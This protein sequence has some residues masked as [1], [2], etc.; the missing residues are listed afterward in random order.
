MTENLLYK[1]EEKVIMLLK[2]LE[3][4]RDELNLV[5]L[6]NSSLKAEKTNS[7]KK[8]QELVSL[9]DAPDLMH[10]PASVT[11]PDVLQG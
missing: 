2:E 11:E 9:F 1:L 6:E 7:I 10:Q 3:A 8:I 5:K 4:L